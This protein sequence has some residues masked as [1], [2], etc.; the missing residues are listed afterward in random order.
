MSINILVVEDNTFIRKFTLRLFEELGYQPD[1]ATNYQEAVNQLY[2]NQYDLIL[3]DIGLP[4]KNGIAVAEKIREIEA[5]EK[6]PNA[7]VCGATAY[8]VDEYNSACL[9][10]GM[11][12]LA[13][14]P[15]NLPFL[16]KLL[17]VATTFHKQDQQTCSLK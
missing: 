1:Y 16:E 9:D 10:A 11:N 12:D 5:K 13:P 15:I 4:D 8:A 14:K 3:T 6:R 17:H 2:N 7:Y